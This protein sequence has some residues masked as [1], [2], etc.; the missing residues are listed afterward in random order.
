MRILTRL[1]GYTSALALSLIST[2]ASADPESTRQAIHY[3]VDATPTTQE[4][5][6]QHLQVELAY[7]RS[8]SAPEVAPHFTY[9]RAQSNG[10]VFNALPAPDSDLI[11]S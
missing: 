5:R 7:N 11:A 3:Y 6:Y 2:W 9:M 1:L 10:F 4:A 8:T